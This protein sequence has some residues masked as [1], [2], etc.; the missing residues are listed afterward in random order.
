MA[1][2]KLK[3][4]KKTIVASVVIAAVIVI[5]FVVYMLVVGKVAVKEVGLFTL[6]VMTETDFNAAMEKAKGKDLLV[7]KDVNGDKT[8][9]LKDGTVDEKELSGKDLDSVIVK[10]EGK[11]YFS[12]L[13]VDL[14]ASV[15]DELRKAKV[16]N[17]LKMT[18][19][20]SIV[21]DIIARLKDF[22][23]V[24]NEEIAFYRDAI[25]RLLDAAPLIQ[26]VY[27][28]QIG[29]SPDDRITAETVD[30][31]ELIDRYG[32]PW[33]LADSSDF[34][35][36]VPSF[37]KRTSG[38]IA[39]GVTCEDVAKAGG[40]F[41]VVT[42]TET[43]ELKTTPYAQAWAE[44]LKNAADIIRQA[45]LILANVPREA[46]MVAYLNGTAAAIESA[47]PYPY[48]DSDIFWNDMMTSESLLYAR[49]GADEVG[50]DGVG[51]NCEMKA[52]FHFNI[53]IR[54]QGANK[55]VD[56]LTGVAQRFENN[57]AALIAEPA[58]YV[59]AEVK[60]HLPLFLDV[61]T[62][63]GDDVGGP[64]GTPVGQSLPNWCGKD[65]KGECQ[66]STM[67]YVNKSLRAYSEALI[68]K[69]ILPLFEPSLKDNFK[70]DAGLDS[71]VYHELFHNIGPRDKKTKP[72]STVTYGE[73]LIAKSGESWRLPLE[74]LKAQTGS[75]Y[76]ASELY[77]DVLARKAKG[78]L[79]ENTFAE[80]AKQY[81]Q[82]I[83]YDMAWNL[84]MVLRASRSGPEFK[85][86]SPYSR[87]A[88]VQ[89]GFLTEKGALAYN[90][91]TKQWSINF[92]KMPE[93][94]SE[95]M[96][97]VGKIYVSGDAEAAEQMFLYYMKGDGEK[98]LHRDRLIEVAGGMPSVLF[99][100]NVKGL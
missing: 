32:H 66:S 12:K 62:A 54:N 96:K 97:K 41:D 5:G 7:W 31:R 70:A 48:A 52:R 60:V 46:K 18:T 29:A 69:Y 17:E 78:E 53:G 14:Y 47:V 63:N 43:G 24:T 13:F 100:Y 76:M 64:N 72:G 3:G 92:D 38:V 68:S 33:C 73:K 42:R 56:A 39:D 80:A 25:K 2:A 89:V 87:L 84:R 20:E 9:L 95:L 40:P 71:V 65:G 23:N 61:I 21:T 91:Q 88:A 94:I 34:C 79:D 57:F 50:G 51:D 37:K 44:E 59:A 93:V 10:K 77:K 58:N 1:Q 27:Q 55:I 49:I 75:L 30:D 16:A 19:R 6:P 83:T 98:L 82:H 90:D 36:A 28:K 45:A 99:D 11:Y 8:F 15:A 67:I 22:P 26:R 35:V 86:K 4:S 85:S 81:K 74:E